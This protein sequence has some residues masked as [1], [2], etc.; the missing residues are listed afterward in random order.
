PVALA[1]SLAGPV[2]AES[3]VSVFG[4]VDLALAHGSG[5]ISNLNQLANGYL[6]TSRLAVKGFE[7]M[8]DGLK[9]GFWI[10]SGFNADTGTGQLTN[11]NNQST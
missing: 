4:V 2:F 10:E 8:G 5:S 1:T 3:N 7:D 6:A 11:T 9:A